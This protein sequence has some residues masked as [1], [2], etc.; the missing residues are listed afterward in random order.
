[1][2]IAR[3]LLPICE[4]ETLEPCAQA[5]FTLAGRF[6]ASV[7]G[8]YATL[9]LV[10]TMIMPDEAGGPVQFQM[11]MEQAQERARA[12]RSSA[13]TAFRSCAGRFPGI[14]SSFEAVEGDPAAITARRGRVADFSVVGR[15][16]DTAGEAATTI[17]DAMLFQTGRPVLVAPR[18]KISEA[19]G[20]CLV[21]AWKDTV[22]AA[23]A[24]AA[25]KPFIAKAKL[26][27]L[28]TAGSDG[29]AQR[30]LDDMA[31]YLSRLAGNV[32]PAVIAKDRRSVAEL[33]LDETRSHEGGLLVMGAY[34]QWRWKEWAFGGV[35]D[36][37]LHETDVPVFMAH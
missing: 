18:S 22:E 15:M 30:G 5:A 33:L 14:E 1:M 37:V 3:I 4:N 36:H 17:V 28:V 34:S 7:E 2:A 20:D 29:A 23:R 26:I 19:L 6:G 27:R 35:T 8:L 31:D 21:I 32:E 16:M 10:R 9:P 12:A 25:A 24:V 13:E 11:L